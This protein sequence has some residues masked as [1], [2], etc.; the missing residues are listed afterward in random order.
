[1]IYL[2]HTQETAQVKQ[3]L[4]KSINLIQTLKQTL[5]DADAEITLLNEQAEE[6]EN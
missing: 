6:R 4:E 1:M 5:I 2:M 3:A